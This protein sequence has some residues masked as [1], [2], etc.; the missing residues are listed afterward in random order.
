ML[1]KGRWSV[2][3]L[4]L[5]A[6]RLS[7]LFFLR[8]QGFPLVRFPFDL[9]MKAWPFYLLSEREGLATQPADLVV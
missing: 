7:S 1:S 9:N 3:G 4:L 2:L 5:E 6:G 8:F